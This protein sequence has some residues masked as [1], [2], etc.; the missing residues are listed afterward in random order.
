[1]NMDWMVILSHRALDAEIEKK[2][3]AAKKVR[4]ITSISISPACAPSHLHIYLRVPSLLLHY[5]PSL[6]L[7]ITPLRYSLSLFPSVTP[8][9]DSPW[10][11]AHLSTPF[12]TGL[13]RESTAMASGDSSITAGSKPGGSTTAGMDYGNVLNT[14]GVAPPGAVTRRGSSRRNMPQGSGL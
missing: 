6:L 12:Q 7:F 11:L 10:F 2:T 9:G 13:S 5:S 14:L 1:M 4:W 3:K 8:L